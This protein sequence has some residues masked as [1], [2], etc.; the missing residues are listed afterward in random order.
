MIAYF[1]LGIGLFLGALFLVQW[2]SRANPATILKTIKIVVAI[3]GLFIAL[4]LLFTGRIF[5]V[6][7]A[8]PLLLP[9]ILRWRAL[10]S[11]MKAASGG[12]SGQISEVVTRFLKM[13]LDH[14]SGDMDGLILTGEREGYW[15][16]ELD[17]VVLEQLHR[18][19]SIEDTKSAELLFAYAARRF[20]ADWNDEPEVASKSHGEGREHDFDDQMDRTKALEVLGLTGEPSDDEIRSA[21]RKLMQK[22][23]PDHGGNTY[24]ATQ[25]NRAKD[26]LL[27][28]SG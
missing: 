24:L 20:G 14:D 17:L 25:V 12:T 1:I 16:S 18:I 5:L 28:R 22:L 3:I 23:H 11:R 10:F 21:H 27:N 8:V 15:L 13:K 26:I 2:F 9:F 19:Y 4:F 6:L 7:A